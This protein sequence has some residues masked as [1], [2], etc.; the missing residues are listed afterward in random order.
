MKQGIIKH[1]KND[2]AL[3]KNDKK[4]ASMFVK[5][6]ILFAQYAKFVSRAHTLSRLMRL[7]VPKP[8]RMQRFTAPTAMRI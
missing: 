2:R 8:Q 6:L 7:C 3:A 4:T 5:T 1:V